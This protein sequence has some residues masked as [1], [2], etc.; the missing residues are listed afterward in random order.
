M[1]LML[2]EY[3]IAIRLCE[4]VA[5]MGFQFLL[6]PDDYEKVLLSAEAGQVRSGYSKEQKVGKYIIKSQFRC[7]SVK[8]WTLRSVVIC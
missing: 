5:N 7:C 4:R 3:A 6:A 8:I 2:K 1:H